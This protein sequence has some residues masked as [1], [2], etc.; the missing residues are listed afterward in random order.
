MVFNYKKWDVFCERLSQSN[1]ISIPAS[2]V[3]CD[4]KNFLVLKHDVETDVKRA[5]KLAE[6]EHKYDH[7]G[8]YYV[9]AYLLRD[10]KNIEILK[11]IQSM[12]HEVSY[13]YDVIDSNH[14]DID[15][16]IKEFESN[17][18]LFEKNGF[19]I[20]TVCQHGNP[21]VER[22]GYNSNRDFF[23]SE[24]VKGLYPNISD[25][26]VNYKDD[27][28]VDYEYYSDAGRSIKKIFDPIN[29]DIVNT[30][31]KDEVIGDLNAL[32]DII[33]SSDGGV[34]V[35]THPH[36]WTSTVL[37]YQL[38]AIAFKLIKNTAKLVLKIP[39][40]KKIMSKYYYLA[41]KI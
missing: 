15:L 21:V 24:K 29:N 12:G 40:A 25:I 8:S 3:S 10:E 39:G 9:Q 1:T 22:M 2:E 11:K 19:H 13:H 17:K 4:S 7:K 26:M 23:R 34:I 16:A 27:Y 14:G 36:R 18:M 32:F 35:S 38:K 37:E 20:S 41:K 33:Y 28:N 31:D 6:I 5:Y 30:S